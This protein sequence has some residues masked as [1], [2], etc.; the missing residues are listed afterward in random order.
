[1]DIIGVNSGVTGAALQGLETFGSKDRG[2]QVLESTD[3]LCSESANHPLADRVE[4]EPKI[5]TEDKIQEAVEKGFGP[6]GN[7]GWS[8]SR[9]YRDSMGKNIGIFKAETQSY[10]IIKMIKLVV[11]YIFGVRDQY[12][13]LPVPE[14]DSYANMISERASYLLDKALGTHSIPET[15]IITVAGTR[16]SFQHFLQ[17][18]EEAESCELPDGSN[19]KSLDIFQRFA[20]LDFI[21]GNLDRK[22][23]NWMVKLD[24]NTKEFD[25]IGAIDNANC[26]P[27]GHLPAIIQPI[28]GV[29]L[30]FS[31]GDS[32]VISLNLAQKSQYKW[33]NLPIA[34]RNLTAASKNLIDS[35]TDEKIK[36]IVKMWNNDLGEGDFNTFFG[37]EDGDSIKA[38]KDRIAVLKKFKESED[39]FTE[40]GSYN[41]YFRIQEYLGEATEAPMARYQF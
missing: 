7:K 29:Q 16:G 9:I 24:Q 20:I 4:V 27:R 37:G 8:G 13:Y 25:A 15:E 35:L 5:S 3:A 41:N 32:R 22:L 40:L 14:N 26:F 10:S 31:T 1:M 21:L 36:E 30:P 6:L 38:F 2:F 34:Q 33:K 23:D 17:S 12:G 11:L 28:A 39:A 19:E 18:Y